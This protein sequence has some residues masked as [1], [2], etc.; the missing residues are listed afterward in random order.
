MYNGVTILMA[1]MP[2][3]DQPMPLSWVQIIFGFIFLIGFF[4][5]KLR[6]YKKIPWLYVKLLNL[7]QPAKKSV[8]MYKSK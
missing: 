8:L 4:V 3:I 5:M 6:V 1:D 7:S 2:M